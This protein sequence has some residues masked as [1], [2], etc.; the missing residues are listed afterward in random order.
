MITYYVQTTFLGGW[1]DVYKGSKL[2]FTKKFNN[3]D[4]LEA[5][6]RNIEK[7]KGVSNAAA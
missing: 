4:Q 3:L 2:L 6:K 5:I 1:V 7:I